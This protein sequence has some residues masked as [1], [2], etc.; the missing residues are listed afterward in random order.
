MNNKMNQRREKSLRLEKRDKML[1]ALE[2]ERRELWKKLSD[3]PL[4]KLA[5]PYQKGWERFF[6][7]SEE[8]KKRKDTEDLEIALSFVRS[9]Q[10]SMANPFLRPRYKGRRFDLW[11]HKLS[12]ISAWSLLSEKIPE[13][14]LMYFR[15]RLR[16]ELT[17]GKI[18]ELIRSGWQGKFYF[19]Y[20]EYAVS[21][22][23]PYWITHS[24]AVLPEVER[25]LAEVNSLFLRDCNE[26]RLQHLKDWSCSMWRRMDEED[27]ALKDKQCARMEI[28]QAIFE[29]EQRNE[30][31]D[32]R[33]VLFLN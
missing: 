5:E 17:R 7:L 1:L 21:V 13:R 14:I 18:R 23:Q 12:S 15:V 9:Y 8:A 32:W 6:V 2:K 3:A 33:P 11:E 4:E 22:V 29:F 24:R 30:L 20:P 10:R 28:E 16:D 26:F 27:H 19:R 31:D 25:R